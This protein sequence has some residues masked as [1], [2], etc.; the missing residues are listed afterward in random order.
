MPYFLK[1][2][3]FFYPKHNYFVYIRGYICIT[4]F[5]KITGKV[6]FNIASYVYILSGQLNKKCQKMV[7]FDK[8]LKTLK[9]AFKQCYQTCQFKL[10]KEC[11]N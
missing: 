10:D 7:H 3:S 1:D 11:Q 4:H 6:S 2:Y 8:F 9:F 5:L